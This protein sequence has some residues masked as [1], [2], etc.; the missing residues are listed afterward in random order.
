MIDSHARRTRSGPSASATTAPQ[1]KPSSTPRDCVRKARPSAEVATLN[2]AARTNGF[3]PRCA[4]RQ[5]S[6]QNAIAI[7]AA[8]ALR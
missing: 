3:G 8:V 1:E 5:T 2:A 7:S 6:G 4:A